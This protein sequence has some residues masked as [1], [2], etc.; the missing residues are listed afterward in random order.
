MSATII[1]HGYTIV[2][3]AS[4]MEINMYLTT[5]VVKSQNIFQK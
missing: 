1:H 5:D 4:S 3:K 2:K